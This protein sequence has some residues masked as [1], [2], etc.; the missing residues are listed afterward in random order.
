MIIN[1]LV[2]RYIFTCIGRWKKLSA[3]LSK[4]ENGVGRNSAFF[5][6]SRLM[7]GILGEVLCNYEMAAAKMLSGAV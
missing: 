6:A 5:E 7:P 3:V 1:L 4:I 2:W